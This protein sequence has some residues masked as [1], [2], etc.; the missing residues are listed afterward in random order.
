MK[1]LILNHIGIDGREIHYKYYPEEIQKFIE[2]QGHIIS[3]YSKETRETR[4]GIEYQRV[5]RAKIKERKEALIDF[6]KFFAGDD[7]I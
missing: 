1:L 3:L 5:M 2:Y 6:L 4:F 7:Y